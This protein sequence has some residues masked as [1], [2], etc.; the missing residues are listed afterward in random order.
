M[1]LANLTLPRDFSV[2]LV[3]AWIGIGFWAGTEPR[4]DHYQ[5]VAR[6]IV[7]QWLGIWLEHRRSRLERFRNGWTF[8]WATIVTAGLIFLIYATNPYAWPL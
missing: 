4:E 1:I 6:Q 8:L 7:G 2:P 3:A 5:L